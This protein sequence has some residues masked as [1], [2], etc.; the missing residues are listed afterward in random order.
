MPPSFHVSEARLGLLRRAS[1]APLV[2]RAA[3][4]RIDYGLVPGLAIWVG[5]SAP[6]GSPD[7]GAWSI[8]VTGPGLPPSDPLRFDLQA[9]FTKRLVWAYG[10]P[11][12]SGLYTLVASN[13]VESITTRFA[14]APPTPLPLPEGASASGDAKRGAHVT[15]NGVPGALSYFVYAELGSSY[16]AG[17]WVTGTSADFLAGTF[18]SGSTYDVYVA[19]VDFDARAGPPPTRVSVSENSYAPASFTAP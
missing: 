12:D 10:S 19:A 4:G 17:Q 3:G 13:G 1:G 5:L 9:N 15:W 7:G 2:L 8:A 14:I 6:D 16:V 11:P 18:T